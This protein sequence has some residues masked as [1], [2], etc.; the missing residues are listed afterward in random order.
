M[1]WCGGQYHND[2]PMQDFDFNTA[3]SIDS[4][5]AS[6]VNYDLNVT[7]L[8]TCL[9][10]KD[11]DTATELCKSK[12]SQAATWVFR[13]EHGG[14]NDLRWKM[15]PLHAAIIFKGN[16]EVIN[17]IIEAYPDAVAMF[18]DQGMLPVSP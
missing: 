14:S 10:H 15:L 8:F 7:D 2:P 12:P 11:W 16:D 6:L 4:I 9:E 17:A 18:D 13:Q 1:N 3:P 5:Q